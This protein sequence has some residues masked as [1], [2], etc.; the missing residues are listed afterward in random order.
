MLLVGEQNGIIAAGIVDLADGVM[1]SRRN[2]R[3]G[4]FHEYQLQACIRQV[5][6]LRFR[7]LLPGLLII[8]HSFFL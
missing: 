4:I 2:R 1:G 7:Y 5:A 3:D 8:V 6:E